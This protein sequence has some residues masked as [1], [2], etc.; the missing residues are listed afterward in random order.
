[1][2]RIGA[3]EF[4]VILF[5][6]GFVWILLWSVWRIISRMGFPGPLALVALIPGGAFVL[7]LVFA[8]IEWPIERDRRGAPDARR[9]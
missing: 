1:M 9:F 6:L 3:A 8:V 5:A 4:L 2:G 7:L